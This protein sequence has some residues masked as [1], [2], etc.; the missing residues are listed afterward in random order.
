MES[1]NLAGQAANEASVLAVL[2]WADEQVRAGAVRASDA[3]TRSVAEGIRKVRAAV[4]ALIEAD[5][6]YDSS[7][8]AL[9][10][11]CVTEDDKRNEFF[12]AYCVA[13]A[14]RAAALAKCSGESK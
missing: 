9:S 12:Q 6:E 7:C 5:Q 1:Q 11:E 10:D 3:E 14:H 8:L 13:K 4:A 2:D